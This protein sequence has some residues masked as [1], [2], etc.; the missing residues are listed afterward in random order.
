MIWDQPHNII[1]FP[2]Y[3]DGLMGPVDA[4]G[5]YCYCDMQ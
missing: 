3:Q 5:Y 4:T 2:G 1:L